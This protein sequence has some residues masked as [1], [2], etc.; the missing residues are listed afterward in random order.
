MAKTSKRHISSNSRTSAISAIS[1]LVPT[2][3]HGLGELLEESRKTLLQSFHEFGILRTMLLYTVYQQAHGVMQR[4]RKH[5]LPDET[6]GKPDMAA[7]EAFSIKESYT[8][9]LNMIGVT[10]SHSPRAVR[11]A[12]FVR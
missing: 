11:S 7:K 2:N 3:I 4:I 5:I 1:E 6:D 8:A 9:S 12:C 10:V